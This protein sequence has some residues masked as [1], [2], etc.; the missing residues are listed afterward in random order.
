[1]CLVVLLALSA[2]ARTRSRYGGALRIETQS[3]PWRVPDGIARKLVFD[4]LTRLD[5]YGVVLLLLAFGF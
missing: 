1:M 3:D 2:S 4:G 5:D